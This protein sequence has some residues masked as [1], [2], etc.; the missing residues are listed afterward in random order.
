MIFLLAEVTTESIAQA[1]FGKAV[2]R[3]ELKALSDRLPT[4]AELM[5]EVRECGVV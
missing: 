3:G 5:F 4:G 2:L 1:V